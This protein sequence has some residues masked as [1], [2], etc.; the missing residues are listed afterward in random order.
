MDN[1]KVGIEFTG[2][3][4]KAIAEVVRVSSAIDGVNKSAAQAANGS[5]SSFVTIR[6]GMAAAAETADFLSGAVTAA[7]GAL[8][9]LGIGFSLAAV[10]G[11]IKSSVEAIDEFNLSVIQ[12]SAILTSLQIA[13]GTAS[14]NIAETYRQTRDYALQTNEALLKIEPSTSLSI[15]GLQRINLELAKSGVA[16]DT[17]NAAQ[18]EG[19]KN[20]ANAAA[21]FSQGGQNEVMLQSEIMLLMQGQAS[22]HSR[23]GSAI[24]AMVGGDLKT[25][26]EQHKQAGDF[27]EQMNKVLAGF[28]P[29]SKDI[30]GTW[31]AVKTSFETTV[32]IIQRGAMQEAFTDIVSLTLEINE[33]L[34]S[35]ADI[36]KNS[37]QTGWEAVRTTV[38]ATGEALQVMGGILQ[39]S[40]IPLFSDALTLIRGTAETITTI[41][42]LLAQSP[43]MITALAVAVASYAVPAVASLALA[44]DGLT[45]AIAASMALN[46]AAWAVAV[47]AGTYIASKSAISAL[48]AIVNEYTGL[49]VTGEAAY[50][51]ELKRAA[52]AAK[53]WDEVKQKALFAYKEG[54]RVPG[55]AMQKELGIN[56]LKVPD[57]KQPP[58]PEEMEDDDKFAERE[59]VAHAAYLEYLKAAGEAKAEVI[60]AAN[61]K[62]EE[63]NKE[64]YE[65]GLTDLQTYLAA[66]HKLN[67]DALQ[68][69]LDAKQNALILAQA[70]EK[71]ALAAQA[72]NPSGKSAGK[73]VN[74]A[75]KKTEEATKAVTE[76]QGQLTLAKLTDADETHKM[77]DDQ[78]RGYQSI[79]AQL[80]D[81]QGQYEAAAL[82]QKGLDESSVDR[83]KLIAEAINGT[84]GAEAAYWAQEALDQKKSQD[85][86]EKAATERA[87][88]TL[89]E[90]SHQLALIDT[91]EK[92]NQIAPGDA[93][94]QRIDLL[95]QQLTLE[96]GLVALHQGNEPDEKKQRDQAITQI[97]SINEKL[98]AQHKILNDH[99][100]MGGAITALHDYATLAQNIGAQVSGSVTNFFK[101]MEDALTNFVVKG[102]LDFKSFA[103]SIISDMVRIV[104][105][106]SIT[107]PLAAAA[108][109]MLQNIFSTPTNSF[110]SAATLGSGYTPSSA[111]PTYSLMPKFSAA[112]GMD[113]PGGLNP[114][115]QAH[116][117]EMVLPAAQADVIRNLA[118]GGGSY[119]ASAPSVTLNITNNSDS[120]VNASTSGVRFD[121]KGLVV[122]IVLENYIQGGVLRQ[123]LGS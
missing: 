92:Y 25:W 61:A 51:K 118:S 22:A 109:S 53:A 97:D 82:V 107:G 114:I 77:T 26:V 80:L 71:T 43:G 123:T 88:F 30:A 18:V 23:L 9:G 36:I 8:A 73:D 39:V 98:L 72:K 116:A 4:S 87:G 7:L 46:P 58:A 55:P 108:G 119:A 122:G 40:V 16:I 62:A 59:K 52:D 11:E 117:K 70:A 106:Q 34:K 74:E 94:K 67:E 90:I 113:I 95:N 1:N 78:L 112:N 76:A 81:M 20:L 38:K 29:A 24:S 65:W 42:G 111:L 85:A 45:T 10:V 99:T 103:D 68:A 121:M 115:I 66:K 64:S 63:L 32:N 48:D 100:A 27:L 89:A 101:G 31:S 102:K 54:G 105:Q 110:G 14:G 19:F 5:N 79:Q 15:K 49:N 6:A 91:A 75:Y 44:F 2:D 69:E 93:A 21:V 47:G 96:Q 120:K 17:N 12:M 83:Q 84:A 13:N 35:H 104:I 60:K 50:N 28:G 56:T 37:V 3:G 33:Y 41:V 57:T 86:M